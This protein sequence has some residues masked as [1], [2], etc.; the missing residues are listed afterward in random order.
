MVLDNKTKV[1]ICVLT[2][3]R[4]LLLRNLLSSLQ[5]LKYDIL[6]IIVVDNHSADD[7]MR[8][9]TTEFDEIKYIR[10]ERNMGAS[11]RNLGLKAARGGIVVTLD[12][13]ILGLSEESIKFLLDLFGGRRGLGAV[14]FKVIAEST[15]RICNWVH[16]R[17]IEEFRDCEFQTYEITEGAVAFRRKVLEECG[18]Y[19]EDFFLSHEGPDLAFR[20]LDKGYEVIYS[21][22]V[23][24]VHYHS[25]LGRKNWLNYYYDTR[26]QM[27][28]AARNFPISYAVRYL[29]RGISSMF[30][31]S[32]RDGFFWYWARGVVDGLR[33]LRNAMKGRNVLR[34]E[35][36][37]TLR[38][39]DS[40]RPDLKY[41][42]GKKVFQK[43]FRLLE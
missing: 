20:I 1:S 12:D 36:M 19:P 17:K 35:T 31:Y 5:S 2:Y 21:P 4:S 18:Y 29:A 42:V 11:A 8:M 9:V 43:K 30:F 27:W 6:E 28:V 32:I 23:T 34:K 15:G 37:R 3:N 16:H 39:I 26:N 25:D 33:G 24:V 38:A 22:R 40:S 41:M 7:T 10:T 14:N 13:D